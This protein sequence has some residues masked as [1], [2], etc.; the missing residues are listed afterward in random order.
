[1]NFLSKENPDRWRQLA[2]WLCVITLPWLDTANNICLILL[3]ILSLIG[4]GLKERLFRIKSNRWAWPFFGYY[5]FLV[6]GIIYTSDVDS[7]LFTL[8]KKITFVA[9][10][11]I[12]IVGGEL[13]EE[14]MSFLKRGFV[15]SCAVLILL[16]LTLAT[17]DFTSGGVANNLGRVTENYYALH[18]NASTAWMHFSYIHLADQVNM[19]PGYFSMYLVFCLII[20]FTEKYKSRKEEVFH[21]LLSVM[22]SC[23]TVMLSTRMA[24]VAF[25]IAIIYLVI[26]KI[27]TKRATPSLAIFVVV[28]SIGL[29]LSFNPVARYRVI[30]EPLKTDY[31]ANTSV[32]EWN[33]VSYR[34]L[35]WQGS[36]SVIRDHLFFGVGTNGWKTA[37]RNF[38]SDYNSGTDDV[39]NSHNQFLQTWMENGILALLAFLFCVFGFVFRAKVDHSHV[40]FILIFSLM[41]MT[42]SILER[43][44]GIVFFTMF[45]TLF[46]AF[47]NKSK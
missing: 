27:V 8:D 7:G 5:I 44:K 12:A 33:S 17:I 35:E 47:V 23:F 11:L 3:F 18:P 15:Y 14:V 37:L 41:C 32:T 20:L 21:L 28:V 13:N 25:T 10:P 22:I 39:P 2:W 31:V 29:L 45:Q 6:L 40:A 36:W 43:Q 30:E 42:E 24:M 16:C 46:L 9:L 26:Q 1:M 34:L 4:P 38:Y 19:H